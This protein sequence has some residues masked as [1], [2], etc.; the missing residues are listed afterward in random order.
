MST[1]GALPSSAGS[2]S[3]A[4]ET[5][6]HPRGRDSRSGREPGAFDERPAIDPARGVGHGILVHLQVI[7]LLIQL[8]VVLVPLHPV[9]LAW[10]HRFGRGVSTKKAS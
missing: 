4:H 7:R 10:I 5:V 8:R 3:G 2:G 6:E 1:G 9:I